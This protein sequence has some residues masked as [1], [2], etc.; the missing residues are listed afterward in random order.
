M[1]A[2]EPIRTTE[3]Y[4][5]SARRW[6]FAM[7]V[8]CSTNEPTEL[9]HA[10]AI[11][12]E[13]EARWSEA[14]PYFDFDYEGMP[15][16]KSFPATR[17]E[18]PKTRNHMIQ[19]ILTLLTSTLPVVRDLK[20]QVA[21]KDAIIARQQAMLTAEELDDEA[22]KA[23]IAELEA[24]IDATNADTTAALAAAE[25]LAAELTAEPATPSVDPDF[26]VTAPAVVPEAPAEPVAEAPTA[27]A[28]EAP[29]E[30]VVVDPA[31][32]ADAPAETPAEQ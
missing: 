13:E 20:A 21:A 29:S 24:Q 17:P 25:A 18:Q 23:R 15:I 14:A 12:L 1:T 22:F 4:A 10:N 19:R 8:S 32:A 11:C 27:E 6:E 5:A 3:Q 28:P 16:P 26:N 2:I 30:A 9:A 31:P 7:M